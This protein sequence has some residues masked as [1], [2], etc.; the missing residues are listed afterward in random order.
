[1]SYSQTAYTQSQQVILRHVRRFLAGRD[2]AFTEAVCEAAILRALNENPSLVTADLLAGKAASLGALLTSAQAAGG[3]DKAFCVTGTI[4]K[5]TAATGSVVVSGLPTDGQTV[6]IGDGTLTKVFEFDDG[7]AGTG[8]LTF[9]GVPADTGT[10]TLGDGT[11]SKVFE[12]D[13]GVLGVASTG[14][15]VTI[16]AVPLDGNTVT[17]TTSTD[18]GATSTTFEFNTTL[19][20]TGSNKAVLT[21]STAA[22]AATELI[23][24]INATG[25]Y[26]S[27][28]STGYTASSGGSGVV[29]IVRTATGAGSETISKTSGTLQVETAT[30]VGTITGNGNATVI[31]TAVG[32]TGT[33]V[34]TSVAVL[35]GDTASVWAGKVRTALGLDANITAVYTVGGSGVTI[36]LTRITAAANDGTLNI[37]LDNGTC[38][39]ITTAATSANSTAGVASSITVT[40][41]FSGGVTQIAVGSAITGGRVGVGTAATPGGVALSTASVCTN[42]INAINAVS[43]PAFLFTATQGAGT[44]V[45][46][47]ANTKGTAGNAFTM[48][49]AATNFTVGAATFAGGQ[50]AGSGTV[51]G[52]NI[53]VAIGASANATAT[54]LHAAINSASMSITS[55]NSPAGTCALANTRLVGA[56][57]N[58]AITKTAS[59]VTVSGMSGGIS[60]AAVTILSDAV[61]GARKA[62]V[63]GFHAFVDTTSWNEATSVTIEDTDGND[64]FV[65]AKAAL[66]GNATIRAGSTN[67]T[68]ASRYYLGT[69]GATGKG[70]KLTPSGNEQSGGDLT[71]TVFGVLK[72]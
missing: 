13:T 69:G 9:T 62:Y 50:A 63:T 35:N 19:G 32:V 5:S 47:T 11:T 64:F 51:T 4:S 40:T 6:T 10:V 67:V 14:G 49:E 57:G 1:M 38:T 60:F 37:S 15:V 46:L 8:T 33:P 61:V 23:A 58:V 31:T 20:V 55:T 7:T 36:S 43:G 56:T 65:L 45:T 59:N 22:E 18:A 42:L 41:S 2:T 25:S 66:V 53:A 39:G 72:N 12:F 29:N 48:S 44:T 70:I 54:S 17:L 28:G 16:G 27:N 71:V 30:A 34:T 24:A 3:E 68:G 21:G 26:A 52:S